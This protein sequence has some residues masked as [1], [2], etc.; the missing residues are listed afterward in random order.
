MASTPDSNRT[1]SSSGYKGVKTESLKTPIPQNI[2]VIG[3]QTYF[4]TCVH[5]IYQHFVA[6]GHRATNTEMFLYFALCFFKSYF[7]DKTVMFSR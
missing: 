2:I 4:Y 6:V 3:I 7:L 1:I 5:V